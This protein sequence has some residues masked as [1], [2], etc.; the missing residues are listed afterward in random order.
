M[1]YTISIY[2]WTTWFIITRKATSD[3]YCLIIVQWKTYFSIP[4]QFSENLE[5]RDWQVM[6]ESECDDTGQL[7]FDLWKQPQSKQ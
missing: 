1:Y 4:Q 3:I 2:V 7:D 5:V 6:A